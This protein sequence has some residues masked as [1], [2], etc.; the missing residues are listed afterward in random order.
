MVDAYHVF[1]STVAASVTNLAGDTVSVPTGD[2]VATN[3]E[4]TNA[5]DLGATGKNH[6][7]TTIYPSPAA[8]GKMYLVVKVGATAIAG[9]A[10][11]D[12][13]IQVFNHTAATSINSGTEIQRF[14][15]TLGATS[16]AAGTHIMTVSLDDRPTYAKRYLGLYYTD[17]DSDISAGTV[18]AYLT[19]IPPRH[20]TN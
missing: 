1:S 17:V 2:S 9:G 6:L 4:A 3:G 5:L 11:S 14:Q 18:Q 15:F 19:P 13:L 12:V 8:G 7:G 16:I 20:T 10:T